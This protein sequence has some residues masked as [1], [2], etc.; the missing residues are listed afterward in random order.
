MEKYVPQFFSENEFNRIGCSIRDINP[1][2]LRRL[3][4]LRAH[5][6]APVYLTSAYRS[7][8]SEKKKGRSGSSAHCTGHAFDI[9]CTDS[10]YRY[11]LLVSAL[12]CGFCRIGI[13][14]T[15]VHVDDSPTHAQCVVWHYY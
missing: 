10:S 3:D 5:L 6:G 4:D 15:F 13:G 11:R 9:R 12:V 8:E 7:V 1:D 14:K 2:S